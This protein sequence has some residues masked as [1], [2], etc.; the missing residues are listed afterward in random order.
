MYDVV[1][2]SPYILLWEITYNNVIRNGQQQKDLLRQIQSRDYSGTGCR[3]WDAALA[4]T[5]VKFAQEFHT[6]SI[7]EFYWHVIKDI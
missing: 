5:C 6:L 7:L 3:D 1:P 4:R 2:Q